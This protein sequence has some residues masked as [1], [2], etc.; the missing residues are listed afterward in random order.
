MEQFIGFIL[1]PVVDLVNTYIENKKV[2]FLV[3]L[4]VCSGI[5]YLANMDKIKSAEDLFLHASLIFT[6]A[7]I[8]YAAYWEKSE[9]RH[10]IQKAMPKL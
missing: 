8:T 4:A 9:V 2:R 6:Q 1:P 10:E 7:Q 5:G 3:A